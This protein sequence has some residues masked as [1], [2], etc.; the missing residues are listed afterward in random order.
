MSDVVLIHSPISFWHEGDYVGDQTSN[1]PIGLLYIAAKLEGLGIDVEVYD[2]FPERLTIESILAKLEASRPKLIGISAVTF[3]TRIAVL[4]AEAIKTHYSDDAPIGLGGMHIST[5]PGFIDRYPCFDFGVIGEGENILYDIYLDICK[6]S[7]PRGIYEADLIKDLDGLP[8]PAR[9][10]VDSRNYYSPHQNREMEVPVATM[11]ASRGCP[12][13][14]AFCSLPPN[15]SRYRT[16]SGRNIV[17]EMEA[18]YDQCQGRYSFVCD[19]MTVNRQRTL[20]MCREIKQRGLKVK[21][22]ANTRVNLVD[23]E[24]IE[25][26]AE[27]GCTDLFFGVESGNPRIRNDV[28]D[29]KITDDEIFRAIKLCRKHGIQSNIYMMLGFPSETMTEIK[30]TIEFGPKSK[31]DF[32]GIHITWPQPGSIIYDQAIAEGRLPA[33][34]IDRYVRG[35]NHEVKEFWPVYV[36]DGITHEQLVEAKKLAYRH[37]YLNPGW[38]GRRLKTYIRDPGKIMTDSKMVKVGI[39]TLMHGASKSAES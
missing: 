39:H 5:D 14:C 29:K 28:I 8:F 12:Y 16:R 7:K 10:L 38:V 4:I 13:R 6:G 33:D 36:P 21:W 26:M 27:T 1:P 15:R 37:F 30:D 2:V 19:T 32:M 11:I 17:D 20:E 22:L 24:M 9:H 23:D 34:T 18:I 3:G 35:D 31:A 25:S